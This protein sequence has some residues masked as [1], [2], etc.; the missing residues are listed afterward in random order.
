MPHKRNPVTCAVVL[1]AATRV[2]P[3][4]STMLSSMVQEEERGL[5]GWQA[6]WET[7][8]EIVRLSAGALHHLLAVVPRLEIDAVRMKENLDRTRGL[9]F[10]EAVSMALAREMGREKAHRLL[11]EASRKS[12]AKQRHLLDILQEEEEVTARISSAML[13]SLFDP[14]KY[15]GASD[16]FVQRVLDGIDSKAYDGQEER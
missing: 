15:L 11:E 13:A 6:E 4:V 14:T 9:I 16:G 8:P 10:A 2:P 12:T 1:A 5:G 3:L 7:L